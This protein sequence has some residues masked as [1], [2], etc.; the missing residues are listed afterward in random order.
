MPRRLVVARA[1]AQDGRHEVDA[2]HAGPHELPQQLDGDVHAGAALVQLMPHLRRNVAE[3]DAALVEDLQAPEHRQVERRASRAL[4]RLEKGVAH[5]KVV[6]GLSD[7]EVRARVHLPL[8][9]AQPRGTGTLARSNDA[10]M[11]RDV[12]P[13]NLE[14]R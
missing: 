11:H 9:P 3:H 7:E 12:A 8:R 1:A 6:D 2:A 10:P 5:A 14:P 13:R 4:V